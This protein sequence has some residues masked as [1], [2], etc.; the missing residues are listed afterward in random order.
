[1]PGKEYCR[2]KG[3]REQRG[4]IAIL[5]RMNDTQEPQ[6][7][8]RKLHILQY[9]VAK[10]R[11]IMDS[12]LNDEDT[13]GHALLLLQE[14]CRA[15]KQK[16]L[17]LHHSWTA[18]EPTHPMENRPPRAAIYFNNNKIPPASIEQIP[19]PH[20]DI[21]AISI[22][23]QPPFVKPILIVNLY[24]E[25]R[26]YS[27]TNELRAI[28]LQHLKITNYDIVLVAGDFNLHH[29][30][31]N[32]PGY[33]PQE[34]EAQTLVETMME[35]NLRP[36]LPLGTITRSP[37]R[38]D[39]S[40]SPT[41]IDLV[42]GNENA[43]EILLKCNTVQE[44]NDHG[45]DH[46]PIEIILDLQPKKLPPTLPS[47]NYNKTNWDLVKIDLECLLPPILNPDNTTPQELDNYASSL[48]SAYQKAV[49]KHTPRKRPSPHCKRWWSPTLST[50]RKQMNHSRNRYW[51][52][53]NER[54]GDEWREMRG[55]YKYE[56]KEAKRRTWET[57]VE[58]ADERTI[59]TVKN[60]I[61]KPP[62]PYYIPTINNATSNEQKAIEFSAAFFP[63]PPPARTDDIG[64]STDP[65]PVSSN[66]AISMTQVQRAIDKISPKKAPGPDEIANITLK[67]TFSVTSCHL[68]SLIQASVN[69]AHFPTAFKSTTTVVLR[70][71]GK[72]DYTTAKAYR[73]IALEN[74]LGKLIES[75]IAELLSHAV[76][77]YQL[78]PP[79]HYGG[80]PG[81]TGEEAMTMLVERIK[82]AWKEGVPYSAVFM[83]VAG[84]FN[85]VHHKRLIHNL[86]KRRVPGFIVR[87][88]ES[89]LCDRSTRLKFNGVESE[90]I[91]TN[92]GVP[93]GSPI[94]PILY[95]FYNADLLEVQEGRSGEL[96][97][98]FI[99]DIAYGVQGETVEANARSLE[100][101]LRKAE[102]WREKHGARFETSKYILIHFTRAR[103]SPNSDTNTTAA[104]IRI[105][106]TTIKPAETARYLGVLFDRKLTFQQHIQYAAKKGTKF[107]LA[108]SRIA[109]CTR[110]PT[111]QQTRNLVSAVVLPR[112]DYAAVVWYRPSQAAPAAAHASG[113]R[114][115]AQ[116]ASAERTAMKAVLGTYRTTATSALHIET[117]LPP[118]HLRLQR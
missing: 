4:T 18:L 105:G 86:K 76:E 59:W 50:L 75:V 53:H 57:F 100:G 69:V 10:K 14:P 19:I 61:D 101:M 81:R 116:L 118:T 58:E 62:S 46:H 65:N 31:W 5:L 97:L 26:T 68:H 43:N 24:N 45:S 90:R 103:K 6:H 115:T 88:V 64:Q 29:A 95:M 38:R 73:P 32:P 40:E 1:M 82:H 74:T 17:L 108:I 113:Q 33:T 28:L 49:A 98:G 36:L 34:P 67:K 9:N 106:D 85:Y 44:T 80:R 114:S 77:E 54:D 35:A 111:Y 16:S 117:S 70:K 92:A 11:E 93:Q 51:R 84:A 21:L 72:P 91:C 96:S 41:S 27:T 78:I 47:Y 2:R 15:Y 79:Q 30:L 3:T 109:N 60:Y 8:D 99:D 94:S 25:A 87:W 22:T 42:W 13:K 48:V 83:D 55:R 66:P 107:A 110:G 56:I 104:Y 7:R 71:P 63:P 112:V 102:S 37:A 39:S 89:F 23:S 52:T 20:P 12:I